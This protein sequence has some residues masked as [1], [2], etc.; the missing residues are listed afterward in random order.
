MGRPKTDIAGKK[1]GRVTGIKFIELQ[2]GQAFW[3]CKCDCGKEFNTKSTSLIR[4]ITKSCGCFRKEYMSKSKTTHG[5]AGKIKG[6]EYM[7]WHSLKDRCTNP[8]HKNYNDYGGRGITVCPTWINSFETFLKDI[9]LRPSSNCSLD[10]IDN[11]KGYSKENCRWATVLEQNKNRR[12]NVWIEYKGS[13]K[14][15]SE[16]ARILEL[17]TSNFGVMMKRKKSIYKIFEYYEQKGRRFIGN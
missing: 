13:L 9:G 12:N 3:L 10:R 4:G 2:S 7:A 11:S 6:T 1:F 15:A 5:Y 16:W 14:I 8:N 17:P